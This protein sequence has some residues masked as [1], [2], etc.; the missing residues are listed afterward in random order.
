LTT[1]PFGWGDLELALILFGHKKS[2]SKHHIDCGTIL[3]DFHDES[4]AAFC[5]GQLPAASPRQTMTKTKR[6]KNSSNY[7]GKT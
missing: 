7:L 6:E 2:Y 1:F 3:F 5:C 4:D